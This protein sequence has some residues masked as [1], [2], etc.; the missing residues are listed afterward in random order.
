MAL[1]L[2][3][4]KPLHSLPCGCFRLQGRLVDASTKSSRSRTSR[5]QLILSA[6]SFHLHA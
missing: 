4:V 2:M 3:R 5:T 1:E 6:K